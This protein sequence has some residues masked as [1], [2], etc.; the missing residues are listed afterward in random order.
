[1]AITKLSSR[2]F[3]QDPRRAKRA[4]K[5]GPVFIMDRGRPSYVLMTAEE[6]DR[7]TKG[8]KSLADLL[9]MPVS[10]DIDFEPPRMGELCELPDR[11]RDLGRSGGSD[12]ARDKD[13][14]IAAAFHSSRKK[15][16]R[17]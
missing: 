6:Y 9:S 5:R 3:E 11:I 12:I 2:E 8:Q 14:M 17:R 10:E 16:R 1:M 15:A 4:A 13:S 7:I